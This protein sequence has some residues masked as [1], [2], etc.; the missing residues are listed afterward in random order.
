MQKDRLRKS[1]K[2]GKGIAGLVVILL[3]LIKPIRLGFELI[4]DAQTA[5]AIYPSIVL[6]FASLRSIVFHPAFSVISSLVGIGLILWS[7]RDT[8][9]TPVV[10]PI[11]PVDFPTSVSLSDGRIFVSSTI[12]PSDLRHLADNKTSLEAHSAVQPY[13]GKWMR[14]SGEVRNVHP[15]QRYGQLV[16]FS[17]GS[18]SL[19]L[20]L[21]DL[22]WKEHISMLRKGQAIT[23]IGQIQV[24]DSDEVRLESCELVSI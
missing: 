2:T 20:L 4:S 5:K 7:I 12:S 15:P 3:S 16:T 13:I 9:P 1:L 19:I 8:V 18:S 17:G 21:F 24:I 11:Q 10:V 14:V 23:V 6:T 22:K